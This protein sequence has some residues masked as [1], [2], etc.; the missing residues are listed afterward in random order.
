MTKRLMV[1]GAVLL[2]A[3]V[4]L[5]ELRLGAE[6]LEQILVKV[7]GDII[8]KSDFEQRQVSALRG[9]PEFA[10]T[11]P[12]SLELQNA[13]AQITPDL[14]VDA[15]EEILLM[16]RGRELNYTLGD[17]QFK[18][19]VDNIKKTNN[20]TD[21]ERFQAAL[22]QEGL[23]LADLRKNLERQMLISQ[24]QRV[25]VM[26]KI[27]VG[28]EEAQA[29]YEAHRAD[30]TTPS[31]MTLRE[32]LIE[33]PSTERGV[34]VAQDDEAKE[35]AE[36]IRKR[37]VDGEPFAR[38]A[39]D[40]S[41]A[42]SKANGGLIG[43]IK[44]D[45][46]APQFQQ[47]LEKMKV[48]DITEVLRTQRGYQILKLESRTETKIRTFEEAR[49]DIADRVAETKRRA[50]MQKYLDRLREQATISWKNAELEKAYEQALAR[51]R[52]E[53]AAAATPKA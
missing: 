10:N 48:G 21:E 5:T 3:A 20:L 51:R 2:A 13:I 32:L 39:A 1:T 34:N 27:S 36:D 11:S 44:S 8:T 18:Q 30:F 37:L 38:L 50:E 31:E 14:I 22:K 43:P 24:V 17:E 6:I 23:T 46:L 47:Q 9:R 41:A 42:A 19:I 28:E 7:N 53:A 4:N 45:E 16:Q 12:N 40:V 26:E 49:E 25:D 33:V 52:Q 35:K 29:Y 15:V